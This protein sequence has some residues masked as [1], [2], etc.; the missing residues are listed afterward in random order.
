[1]EFG[2]WAALYA[3]FGVP[4]PILS[5][6]VVSLLGA[7]LTSGIWWL[8]AEAYK[9]QQEQQQRDAPASENLVSELNDAQIRLAQ[10]EEQLNQTTQ[11]VENERAEKNRERIDKERALQAL[12]DRAARRAQQDALGGFMLTGRQI[13]QRCAN[14]AAPAPAQD[15]DNWAATTEE[16]LANQ[17][18][19][20]YVARFRSAAGLPMTATAIQSREHRNVWSFMQVRLA[21]LEQFIQETIR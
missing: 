17:M 11:T 13:Q 4:Y 12:D 6:V 14:E 20:A 7:A 15:A 21:R 19:T 3:R 2:W 1:M 10:I 9:N 16:Y 5:Y 18:G 8:T